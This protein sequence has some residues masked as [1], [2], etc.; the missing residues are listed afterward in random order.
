MYL[1]NQYPLS[2]F[3]VQYMKGK[4]EKKQQFLWLCS[5]SYSVKSSEILLNLSSSDHS[6]ADPETVIPQIEKDKHQ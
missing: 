2:F 6:H 5:N 4:G 1:L 3:P